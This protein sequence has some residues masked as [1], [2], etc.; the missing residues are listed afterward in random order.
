MRL[1]IMPYSEL[2]GVTN[3]LGRTMEIIRATPI[4]YEGEEKWYHN[5][6]HNISELRQRWVNTDAPQELVEGIESLES[7]TDSVQHI[8]YQ[9]LKRG[10]SPKKREYCATA[11]ARFWQIGKGSEFGSSHMRTELTQRR[12][13]R[14]IDQ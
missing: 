4:I 6:L 3:E 8:F 5:Q 2:K 7:V 9:S 1:D 14:R 10:D 11:V 13:L 12:D